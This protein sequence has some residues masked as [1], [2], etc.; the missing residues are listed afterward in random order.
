MLTM[1]G[2]AGVAPCG[3]SE[4][5]EG[6]SLSERYGLPR[7]NAQRSLC[8]RRDPRP[9]GP[10]GCVGASESLLMDE[11]LAAVARRGTA[12]LGHLRSKS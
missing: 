2:V 3:T 5:P 4:L 1:S 8:D 11:V 9:G 10:D 6:T 12:Q 7:P